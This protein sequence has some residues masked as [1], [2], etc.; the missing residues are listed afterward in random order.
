MKQGL[1]SERYPIIAG[2]SS[3]TGRGSLCDWS[4]MDLFVQWR[5]GEERDGYRES[6][7]GNQI[8]D[9]GSNYAL[10]IRAQLFSCA[11][12]L[13][14]SQHRLF[15]FA[16]DI[17]DSRA[18]FYRFDSSCVVVSEPIHYRDDPQPL[19]DFFVRYFS[20]SPEQRGHDPTVVPATKA[21]KV[22]FQA[23]IKEYFERVETGELRE[24]PDIHTLGSAVSKVQVNDVKG[25]AR[26]YLASKCSTIPVHSSPCGRF[27]RGYIATPLPCDMTVPSNTSKKPIGVKQSGNASGKLYWLKDCWRPDTAESETSIYNKLKAKGLPNLPDIICSGD[28]SVNG[29]PQETFNDTLVSKR[30]TLVWMRFTNKI[31]HR[32]HHRIVAEI[33]I[34]FAN[35]E[36]ARQL[37]LVGRDILTGTSRSLILCNTMRSFGFGSN[38]GCFPFWKG[39]PL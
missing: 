21:E 33:L 18:R 34:P 31:P 7:V 22:L 30:K 27:T 37:L 17:Y 14:D 24:H 12:C 2:Y 15:L 28:V 4:L 10:E 16:V 3:R 35:I 19:Y 23:T 6:F 5:L 20:L 25:K 38:R 8:L 26:W 29:K 9:D 1:E 36:N 39:L 13:M 32:I 11:A